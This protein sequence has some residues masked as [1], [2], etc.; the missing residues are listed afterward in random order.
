MN[1]PTKPT[2]ADADQL[3]ARAHHGQVDKAGNP[4]IGHPR[5]VA[6]ALAQ[7]G[8]DAVMA[9]LLHDVVEDTD[10][11][12]DDLRAAGYPEVVVRAVDAVTRRP[13]E[14]YMNLI[15]RAAADPLG[16][17]VKLADNAHNSDPARLALLAPEQRTQLVERYAKAR[18]LLEV[19]GI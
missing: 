13:G 18:T 16:R 7:Y 2:V 10:V 3:A 4:Y 9:G 11:T 17:L 6:A 8:D 1:A 5:A 19:G 15:R 12:L 14:T